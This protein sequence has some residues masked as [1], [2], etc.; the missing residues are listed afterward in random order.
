MRIL[1]AEDDLTS[2]RLLE[3]MLTKWDYDVVVAC[4]GAQAWTALQAPG[5]PR[6]AILDWMMPEMDGVE[7][8]RRVRQRDSRDPTYIILLTA[9]SRKKDMA[10]GL[11]AGANDYIAK[12]F[13]KDE[14]RARVR[15]G[16]RVVDLQGALADRV[17][18]LQE[19]LAH[20]RTLQGI[21]PICM[22]CHRIR[23]DQQSWERI[24]RYIEGH[25][26]A[27]FT[28]SLCPECLEKH[29]PDLIDPIKQHD[30]APSC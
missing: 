9:L 19:S 28:H 15:V 1:I 14:L 5:A 2:R 7:I 21:L 29:Y 4:D 26:D 17:R 24:E 18:E 11:D 10:T 23:N 8:C 30:A 20:I 22:H 3:A 16:Q 25:S 6:L 13:D 27:H 12:P